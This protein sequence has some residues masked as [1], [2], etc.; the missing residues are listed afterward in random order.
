MLKR[1][2]TTY[3]EKLKIMKEYIMIIGK[4]IRKD[5]VYKDNPIGVWQNN[6]R[7]ADSQSKLNISE[8]LRREFEKIGVLGKRERLRRKK[9][10]ANEKY[11][12]IMEFINKNPS[13]PIKSD[14]I[15]EHGNPIEFYIRVLQME[16]NDGS[17]ELSEEQISKLR[18]M[19]ILKTS[20]LE[21]KKKSNMYGISESAVRYILEKYG[22]LEEFIKNYKLG[23]I[24]LDEKER[25]RCEIELPQ[26]I[27]LS[28]KN[29]SA[30]QKRAYVRLLKDVSTPEEIAVL[31]KMGY[32]NIDD[33]NEL[34][35]M[36]PPRM[37]TILVQSYGLEEE[38]KT[39]HEIA[40][41]D[42]TT[43]QNV[44]S[45]KD[46]LLKRLVPLFAGM[47]R[48]RESLE[49]IEA[50]EENLCR[51]K[52]NF[53]KKERNSVINLEKL[54]K[55]KAAYER[56]L[57]N[58]ENVE[59]IFDSNQIIR[60]SI[61]DESKIQQTD[62]NENNQNIDEGKAPEIETSLQVKKRT[63]KDLEEEYIS[64]KQ[65]GATQDEILK[66]LQ[67]LLELNGIIIPSNF[68]REVNED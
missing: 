17:L 9:T 45:K 31:S 56:A 63:V 11:N 64:L 39:M 48:T 53:G 7:L 10:S 62:D 1:P 13:I 23:N 24:L 52:L 19:K 38:A 30:R 67:E 50:F 44:C 49:S 66:C 58:Y 21:I 59:S 28:S 25:K 54:K 41:E 36:L 16:Y 5:T 34:I 26:G 42:H 12:I 37:Q 4:D 51:S 43:Y 8:S 55:E 2:R 61:L 20:K 40:E 14:T 15:D 18:E 33:I 60:A 3:E 46:L 65:R 68:S 29:I 35:H 57:N 27:I 47:I 6:M 32:I 22:D